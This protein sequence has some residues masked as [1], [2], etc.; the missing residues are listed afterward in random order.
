V[1]EPSCNPQAHRTPH[2]LCLPA[3][4][5][6]AGDKIE[7]PAVCAVP[8]RPY[9]GVVVT[10]TQNVSEYMLVLALCLVIIIIF[11]AH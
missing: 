3:K 7:A 1:A 4:T 8:F 11:W 9:C 6:L 2:A 5:P 10:R